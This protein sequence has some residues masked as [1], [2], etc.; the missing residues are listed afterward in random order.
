ML[1]QMGWRTALHECVEAS[2][3]EQ[4]AWGRFDCAIF[5]ADCIR[6]MTGEDIASSFRGTYADSKGAVRVLKKAGFNDLPAMAEYHFDEIAPIMAQ[7][8]DIAALESDETG[9][10]LGVFIGERVISRGVEG[11]GTID[12]SRVSRAFR[13]P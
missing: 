8:G 4:F 9:W 6:A 10:T 2:R 13:V 3:R 12:R 7:D 11:L 5:A 1:R